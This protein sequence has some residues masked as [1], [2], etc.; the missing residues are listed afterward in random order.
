MQ[1]L[2]PNRSKHNFDVTSTNSKSVILRKKE[3][4]FTREI[5]SVENY[6]F[7][8]QPYKTISQIKFRK[9][10]AWVLNLLQQTKHVKQNILISHIVIFSLKWPGWQML[11]CSPGCDYVCTKLFFCKVTRQTETKSA[12]PEGYPLFPMLSQGLLTGKRLFQDGAMFALLQG[13]SSTSSEGQQSC[14]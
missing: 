4:I 5:T 14:S 2:T 1:K 6:D 7:I 11:P 12:D 3:I 9:N 10:N 13:T 8:M